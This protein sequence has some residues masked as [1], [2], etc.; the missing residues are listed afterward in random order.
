MQRRKSGAPR[1]SAPTRAA[2]ATDAEHGRAPDVGVRRARWP[3]VAWLVGPLLLAFAVGV[4]AFLVRS[5]GEL[6][7]G[8]VLGVLVVVPL[9]WIA[10]SA[11]WPARAERNCPHCGADALRR[12]DPRT[13]VGVA[14][15]ACG[16]RDE[17]RSAW[18][19]AEEEGPLE[20]IVL[21]QRRRRR[22][23]RTP[24]DSA[25]DAD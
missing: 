1:A 14:C 16:W 19:L 5:S 21:L 17:A 4:P 22:T 7:W 9:C 3:A 24:V 13:T 20:R 6:L 23:S 10:V 2:D 8:T 11:L 15:G 25:G 18:Y 12:I